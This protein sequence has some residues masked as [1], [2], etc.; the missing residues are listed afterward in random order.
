MCMLLAAHS[1]CA[2]AAGLAPACPGGAAA[3][4]S[5]ARS[6]KNVTG[7]GEDELLA[8]LSRC[9][10][11]DPEGAAG[12]GGRERGCWLSQ[13]LAAQPGGCLHPSPTGCCVR[14]ACATRV[15]FW[16]TDVPGR[17]TRAERQ[18]CPSAGCN[19][20]E[21]KANQDCALLEWPLQ[22]PAWFSPYSPSPQGQGS[23]QEWQSGGGLEKQEPGQNRRTR[24]PRERAPGKGKHC[25]LKQHLLYLLLSA[26]CLFCTRAR[27]SGK[28]E[29]QC[30]RLDGPS[31]MIPQR[32]GLL[33][34]LVLNHPTHSRHPQ[35]PAAICHGADSRRRTVVFTNTVLGLRRLPR[36][37]G[38][39]FGREHWLLRRLFAFHCSTSFLMHLV[40]ILRN[41]TPEEMILGKVVP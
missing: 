24:R 21:L 5:A 19:E 30:H 23:F 33:P 25:F 14:G 10:G 11:A 32:R 3:G 39:V 34:R 31:H 28:R 15:A 35:P 4:L 20:S 26:K 27:K 17:E 40:F 8:V 18:T 6:V 22:S 41:I 16:R 7:L 2:A 1:A 36:R 29:A 37:R 12:R 13:P 38:K 9:R